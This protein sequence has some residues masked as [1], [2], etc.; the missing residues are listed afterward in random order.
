M[1]GAHFAIAKSHIKSFVNAMI[2]DVINPEDVIESLLFD[3]G[4]PK[5][6][7]ELINMHQ[8]YHGLEVG[9]LKKLPPLES[10]A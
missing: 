5:T 9:S 8:N 1:V 2:I 7:V 4:L 10:V 6:A 3:N